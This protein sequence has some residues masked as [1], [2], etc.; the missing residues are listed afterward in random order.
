MAKDRQTVN[1]LPGITASAAVALTRAG[2]VSMQDLL[3][4][5]FDRVAYVVDD[6]NEAA[7]LVK[8]ARR[9]TDSRR[10]GKGGV[11]SLVPSPLSGAREP[12]SMGMHPRSSAGMTP[13]T[14]AMQGAP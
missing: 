2:I 11:E 5:E 14:P 8:E 7:R 10:G 6:Y 4:A 13:R 9:M 1:E 12:S 3:A